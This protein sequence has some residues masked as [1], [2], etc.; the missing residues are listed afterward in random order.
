MA[1]CELRPGGMLVQKRDNSNVNKKSASVSTIRVKVK[2]GSSYH[3]ISISSHAN[4]GNCSPINPSS[5][6]FF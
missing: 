5:M 3:E 6:F 1:D 4:F 2:Y